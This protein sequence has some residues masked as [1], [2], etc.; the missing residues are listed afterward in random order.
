[1]H[2]L[3]LL[4][5]LASAGAAEPAREGPTEPDA[6]KTAVHGGVAS[7]LTSVSGPVSRDGSAFNPAFVAAIRPRVFVQ[8]GP[9]VATAAWGVSR[10][11]TVCDTCGD[12]TT[13]EGADARVQP[14]RAL[15][16]DD[17]FL[18]I[19]APLGRQKQADAQ[20]AA[21]QGLQPG[22]AVTGNGVVQVRLR[23]DAVLPA[24]RDAFVCNPFYGAVG[25]GTS[26][27]VAAG[28]S[29]VSVSGSVRRSFFQYD[30]VPVGRPGCSRSADP[31]PTLAGPVLPTPWEA[32]R[33]T[34]PNAL[35]AVATSV[36]WTNPH[37]LFTDST[38]FFTNAAIGLHATRRRSPSATVVDTLSGPVR[39]ADGR[40][41]WTT[42]IPASLTA[43]WNLSRPV[44]VALTVSNALPG[45]LTDPGA[46]VRMLPSTTA[47]TLSADAHF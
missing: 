27:S 17:L 40:S 25:A 38:T 14:L 34:T 26:L 28:G 3:L 19:G 5:A 29:G 30:A 16:S 44:S 11:Q 2:P 1:M 45:V 35:G 8:R 37:R 20:Q 43:G 10:T 33:F 15:D 13:V 39:V 18:S 31:V 7:T 21:A 32:S 12:P 42:R 47:A 9:V 36:T 23:A 41:P 22:Q 4:Y 6:V 46:S 24:S